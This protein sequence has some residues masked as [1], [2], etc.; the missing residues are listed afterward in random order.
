MA[1]LHLNGAALHYRVQGTGAPVVALHGSASTGAQ[2]RSLVGYLGGRFEVFTPDL[3]GYGLSEPLILSAGL[4]GDAR[5]IGGLIERIGGRVHL[6][7]HGYGGAVALKLAATRPELLRSLTVIE[8][9][10]FHLLRRGPRSDRLLYSDIAAL[11]AQVFASAI[12]GDREEA[13]RA[14][15]TTG[16]AP[17]AWSRTSAGL[18]AVLLARLDRVCADLRAVMFE[19]GNLADLARIDVSAAGGDGPRLAGAEPATDRARRRDAAAGGASAR[20]PTP[21]HMAP[22]TDPHV[23]D[24]MIA[25]HLARGRPRRRARAARGLSQAQGWLAGGAAASPKRSVARSPG[26]LSASRI[27]APCIRATAATSA[28]PRPAPGSPRLGS[29]RT[30]RPSARA[31]SAGGMP[32]PRSPTISAGCPASSRAAM[33]MSVPA[34]ACRSA[35]ST[36]FDSGQRQQ[37]VVAA[38]H[39]PGRGFQRQREAALLGRGLVEL[40]DVGGE[41]AEFHVGELLGADPR[42]DARD[43]EQPGRGGE[44]ALRLA[45]RLL[46]PALPRARLGLV[47]GGRLEMAHQPAERAAQVV[48]QA[49]G[50]GAQVAHQRLDAVEHR[51]QGAGELVELVAGAAQRHPAVQRAGHDRARRAVDLGD[52]PAHQTRE[53]PAGGEREAGDRRQRPEQRPAERAVERGPRRHVAADQQHLAVRQAQG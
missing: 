48:R 41:P 9:A 5:A 42:L 46:D 51:V 52:A 2:W 35:F 19:D 38:D 30:N 1:Q 25:E 45:Q 44:H 20:F 27:S 37:L 40:G 36:R 53:Q 28:R 23:V 49:V 17:G 7:G 43:V 15:S 21:G 24:P 8:P 29:R 18:R 14:A 4:A 13:M 50:D 11:A 10:A 34:G 6:V 32:G 12:A 16:T 26:S 3:P 33:S 31:R 39:E 47:L 22:L